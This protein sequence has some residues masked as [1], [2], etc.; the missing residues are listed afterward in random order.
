MSMEVADSVCESEGVCEVL[1][2]DQPEHGESMETHTF[3]EDV[4]PAA[5]SLSSEELTE[6]STASHSTENTNSEPMKPRYSYRWV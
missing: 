6:L 2:D 1:Y 3:E 5:E 4:S